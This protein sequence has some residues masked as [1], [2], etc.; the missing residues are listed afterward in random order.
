MES[1]AAIQGDPVAARSGGRSRRV[2]AAIRPWLKPKIIAGGTVVLILIFVGALA[3]W[4]SPYDPNQQ[5]LARTLRA[6]A[7][8]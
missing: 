7:H 5:N 6:L 2:R 1:S 3:P 8:L 4:I